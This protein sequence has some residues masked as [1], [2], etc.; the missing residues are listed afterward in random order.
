MDLL[1]FAIRLGPFVPSDIFRECLKCAVEARQVDVRATPYD[2]PD[3]ICVETL[4]GRK[5][6]ATEQQRLFEMAGPVRE[7]L[8]G[9][10]KALGVE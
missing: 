5:E 4:G 1:F 10:Y 9:C 8:M 3:A 2:V 7:R 6:Y